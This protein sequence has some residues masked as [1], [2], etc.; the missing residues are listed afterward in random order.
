MTINERVQDLQT[1][2]QKATNEERIRGDMLHFLT[3]LTIGIAVGASAVAGIGGILFHLDSKIVGGI[4]LIPG[5]AG[6]AATSLK[7]QPKANFHFRKKNSLVG[8][9]RRLLY[10]LPEQPS[11]EN[12]AAIS[13]AWTELDQ[14]THDAWEKDFAFNW[15]TSPKTNPTA[16]PKTGTIDPD[17]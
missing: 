6:V 16:S 9:E 3:V 13:K 1:R 5:V 2:L 17:N 15:T 10:E 12:V 4:A 11:A 7:L 14:T 8:L